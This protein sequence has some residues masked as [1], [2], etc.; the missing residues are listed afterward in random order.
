MGT[1]KIFLLQLIYNVVSISAVQQSDPV[2]HILELDLP[3]KAKEWDHGERDEVSTAGVGTGSSFLGGR[4][5]LSERLPGGPGCW[6]HRS[7][8]ILGEDRVGGLGA[9]GP[10][11]CHWGEGKSRALGGGCGGGGSGVGTSLSFPPGDKHSP[12]DRFQDLM[13]VQGLPRPALGFGA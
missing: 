8:G 10:A 1:P 3:L 2:V 4:T 11:I 12:K 7:S 13:K 5:L 6:P 9:G